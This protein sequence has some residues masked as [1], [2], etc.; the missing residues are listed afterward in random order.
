[1]A[2]VIV[3]IAGAEGIS[4][5]ANAPT[6]V[7]VVGRDTRPSSPAA[8]ALVMEGARAFT[9][10]HIIDIGVATTPQLHHCVRFENAPGPIRARFG[11]LAGYD[12][13]L[14]EAY[15]AL[16]GDASSAA[17]GPLVIDC[18]N[19]VGA[20]AA[21]SLARA[22]EG[23]L[24]FEL[25][26][27]GADAASAA[28]L[29]DGCGAEHVQ[30]GRLP[31]AGFTADSCAGARCA[32][33]DG[34]ADRLVYFYWASSGEWRLLDGDKI[35]SLSASFLGDLLR[36]AGLQVTGEPCVNVF[37]DPAH[38]IFESN[39]SA[40]P[41]PAHV[42]RSHAPHGSSDA[43]HGSERARECSAPAEAL[44]ALR[45]MPVSIGIVQTAYANG[46][47]SDYM[48]GALG[49]PTAIAKTGV[50]FVH[51]AAAAYDIG[52][53]FEANGHGTVLFHPAFLARLETAVEGHTES[54]ALAAALGSATAATALRQLLSVS[55]VV[56]QAVGDALSDAL[57]I[58]AVL[59]LKGWSVRDWDGIYEDLPS[60]QAKLAVPDRTAFVPVADETRLV[61]PADVQAAV[62]ARVA[63]TPHGR[64]FVRPSGTED[65]VR[66]YAEAAT[67]DA[68]DAL[69]AQLV[70]DVKRIVG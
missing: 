1:M 56:N 59:T 61:T 10:A 4:L 15:G 41:P 12:V 29:N 55:R 21:Q 28:L 27:T 32:S 67:Q 57:F 60:R 9:G 62:D 50:K 3:R 66:F 24:Q 68:A 20:A 6:P 47:S 18:A 34:D 38:V 2:A 17:R 63:A 45:S 26:N 23:I 35:A 42:C 58:E 44:E 53:Y 8:V 39:P 14:R 70:N 11:G 36:A 46:A 64:A 52:V 16:V 13:M 33:L 69:C 65:V 19:G 5:A 43:A 40:P 48:R 30:K 22:F 7:I 25:R 51:A 49:L 54:G 31:P 37:F